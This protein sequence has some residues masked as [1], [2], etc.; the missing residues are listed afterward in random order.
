MAEYLNAKCSICGEKYH[1]CDDCLNTRTFTP[2]R[3]IACSIN[4]YKIF[5]ALNDFTNKRETKERT[6]Q[7]LSELDL[8]ELESFEENIKLKIKEIMSQPKRKTRDVKEVK[9]SE[10][11]DIESKC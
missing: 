1:V 4:C 6:R 7:F 5:I 8:S 2:W 11:Q 10:N 9:V 3:K